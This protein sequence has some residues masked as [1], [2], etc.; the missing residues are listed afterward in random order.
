MPS[1]EI[2]VVLRICKLTLLMQHFIQELESALVIALATI[3]G[4]G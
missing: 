3:L 4:R 1:Y 2:L